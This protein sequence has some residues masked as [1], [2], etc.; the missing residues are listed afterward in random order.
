ML[1]QVCEKLPDDALRS[2][3]AHIHLHDTAEPG[4]DGGRDFS[5]RPEDAMLPFR[6]HN[7]TQF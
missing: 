5:L 2:S 6:I 7:G 3:S 4:R 1:I